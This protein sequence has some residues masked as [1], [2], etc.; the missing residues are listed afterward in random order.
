MA[1]NMARVTEEDI[2]RRGIEAKVLLGLARE[3]YKFQLESGRHFLHEHPAWG[4][5][6][7][8]GASG[9]ADGAPEGRVSRR[10]PVPVW[11]VD[12]DRRWQ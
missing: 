12:L 2:E 6:M 9:E 4:P 10:A 7:G 3:V 5:V 11:A 1:L 8:A